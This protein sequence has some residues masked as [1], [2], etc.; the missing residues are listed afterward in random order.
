MLGSLHVAPG[1]VAGR[2]EQYHIHAGS[3][4]ADHIHFVNVADVEAPSGAMPRA[5][6]A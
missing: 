1:V 5:R 2:I 3:P 6:A 4:G